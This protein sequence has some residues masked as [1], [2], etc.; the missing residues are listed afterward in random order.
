M[1][2]SF[3][4]AQPIWLKGRELEV[5]LGAKFTCKIKA[6]L[7]NKYLLRLT[8]ATLLRVWLNGEFLHYGPAR[9]PHG[10]ARIDELD[11]THRLKP[12]ENTFIFEVSGYN[13]Y[14]FYTLNG[15]SFLQAEFLENNQ[16]I[17]YTGCE[18]SFVGA[19]YSAKEQKTMRYSYQRNFTEIYN[20]GVADEIQEIGRVEHNLK[21]VLR[22][23]P[24]PD[25]NSVCKPKKLME[26]GTTKKLQH[27]N[28]F[29]YKTSRFIENISEV[30]T[31][32]HLDEIAERPF[33]TFQDYSFEPETQLNIS[34]PEAEISREICANNYLVFDFGR[35]HTGFIKSTFIA[36]EDCEIFLY[37]D[38]KMENGKFDLTSFECINLVKYSLKAGENLN[39]LETFEVYSLK[40]LMCW[41]VKGK[42][43]LKDIAVRDYVYP[44]A[45][46]TQFSCG[47]IKLNAIFEAAMET[48]RQNTLDTFMDCPGRERAGWLCDSYFTAQSAQFYSGE[49]LVEKVMLENFILPD[50]FPNIPKGMLPMCYPADHV[51]GGFIPQWPLWYVLELE[52]YLKR[53]PSAKIED[54]KELCYNLLEYFK[55]FVNSDGLLE[56][57]ENWNFIE[58]SEANEWTQDVSYPTNMIY[59]KVLTLIG[60]WYHDTK[61]LIESDRVKKKIIEQSFDGKFFIDNAIR[62]ADGS[63]KA[64]ENRSEICQYF[65]FFFDIVVENDEAFDY[66]RNVSLN[67]FG[68]D[69]KKKGIMPEISYANAFVGNYIRMLLLI[70]W[71]KYQ[72][73]LDEVSGYFYGM[74]E[75]TGTLWEHDSVFG[76]LNHGFASFIGVAIVICTTGVL[77]INEREKKIVFNETDVDVK[78]IKVSIG[79]RNGTIEISKAFS[80]GGDVFSIPKEYQDE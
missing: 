50:S 20:L 64:T 52:G 69:R 71:K 23:V 41:V 68:P 59:S 43:I 74:V 58:W 79:L 2:D 11:L 70:R 30:F 45:K 57:L 10:F 48:Y 75:K 7:N 35:I 17:E 29:S 78:D 60:E 38:E 14:S 49:S 72:Q 44:H 25:F 76:S 54:F 4:L 32:F 65:A 42:V 19:Q 31:G 37:F 28:D 1:R 34:L 13:C 67:V 9:A 15:I 21:F 26:V 66:L 80:E 33:E 51:D 46:N 56:K 63:L 27:N 3:I 53:D 73:V 5:N 36:V 8:G 12:G 55:P 39:F 22:G 24:I 47:D 18:S 16:V 40:Y 6:D 62:Q 61:L 77:E